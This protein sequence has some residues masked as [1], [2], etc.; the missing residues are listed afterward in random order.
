MTAAARLEFAAMSEEPTIPQ[1]V[2]AERTRCDHHPAMHHG[3]G[4]R[5]GLLDRCGAHCQLSDGR[6]RRKEGTR[7]PPQY[8]HGCIGDPG[9]EGPC[10]FIGP[11]GRERA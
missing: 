7:R 2:L 1:I 11:C 8:C 10:S 6:P 3:R 9:H 5:G 4:R